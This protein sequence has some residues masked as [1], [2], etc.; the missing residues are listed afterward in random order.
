MAT[1]PPTAQIQLGMLLDVWALPAAGRAP[2][3]DVPH[4]AAE[5]ALAT[6]GPRG[7]RLISPS[8]G[9]GRKPK[10]VFDALSGAAF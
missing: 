3:P 10:S 4:E 1:P 6:G 9:I 2:P 7:C 8:T 5:G